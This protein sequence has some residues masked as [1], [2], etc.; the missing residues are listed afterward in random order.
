MLT[1][2]QGQHVSAFFFHTKAI[3]LREDLLRPGFDTLQKNFNWTKIL[4]IDEINQPSNNFPK[5]RVR[6]D[7]VETTQL[8]SELACR[9]M[10]T[11]SKY[12]TRQRD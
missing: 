4:A 5:N 3:F 6:L 2:K 12:K 9:Q 8:A 7:E 1:F 10:A 11:I